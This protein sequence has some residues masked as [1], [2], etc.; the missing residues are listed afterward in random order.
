MI[1][2]ATSVLDPA[3]PQGREILGLFWIVLGIAGVIFVVVTALVVIAAIRFRER[4]GG[5]PPST[6]DENIALELVWTVIPTLI[7]A[8]LFVLTVRVM[9]RVDPNPSDREPDLVVVAHQWWWELHYPRYGVTT[10]N[11]FHL[12]V[13]TKLL[14]RLE[15]ADVVHDFWVPALGKKVDAIPGH[16]NTLSLTIDHPGIFLGTCD[17]FCGAEH[18]WMRI[19]VIGQTAPD[20][21]AWAEHQAL[22]AAKPST[23]DGRR[24][25]ELFQRRTCASCHTI[26]GTTAHGKTGPNLTHLASRQ[27]LASGA[28]ANTP[29]ELSRWI[30]DPQ[31]I[32]PDCDMPDLHLD[33]SEVELLTAYLKELQ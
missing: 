32:K 3:S 22:P 14:L 28:L 5:P 10:A 17:E 18:A 26:A 1:P 13:K 16:P 9:H 21:E 2:E 20:F 31:G 6:T 25:L 27:T 12:P 23:P 30:A 24:G 33:H 29:E 4:P 7:L 19:R 15:S 11:E 8:V